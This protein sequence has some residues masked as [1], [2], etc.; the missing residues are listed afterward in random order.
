M[1][2]RRGI[3]IS[4]AA[5][6][7]KTRLA[8]EAVA[9]L[10]GADVVRVAGTE[11]AAGIPFGA[12]AA[13]L[14]AVP[15]PAG[16]RPRGNLFAWAAAALPPAHR[17][18]LFVDDAHLLDRASAAL[19]LHLAL[20][21]QARIVATV[22][23]GARPVDAVTALWKDDLLPRL[24]LA[25]F[26]PAE[27]ARVLAG[28]LDGPIASESADRLFGLTE[29]NV[30]FL[31][32]VVLAGLDSGTLSRRHGLWSWHGSWTLGTRL[33]ELVESRLGL[34]DAAER[35][36][37]EYTAF[38]EPL[39]LDLLIRL[40]GEEAVDRVE[41]RRLIKITRTRRR[42]AVRPAH[43]LYG[44]AVRAA[45]GL[46]ARRRILRRL[47][48]ATEASGARRREDAL[49]MAVWRLDGGA[50]ADPEPLCTAAATAWAALDHESA[51]RLG[52]A[53]VEAGGGVEAAARLAVVLHFM[54]RY[55]EA[56][57]VLD[58]VAGE[59]AGERQRALYV[60]A[61]ALG[62]AW[63][64]GRPA[65]ATDLLTATV[66]GLREPFW[67]Q[68]LRV[69]KAVFLVSG[70]DCAGAL[71]ETAEL[72]ALGPVAPVIDASAGMAESL[73]LAHLG[74]TGRA[75]AIAEAAVAARDSWSDL[76]AGGAP[77]F[78]SACVSALAYAG[79]LRAAE[80]QAEEARR[81]L[82]APG[83]PWRRAMAVWCGQRAMLLR[84]RGRLR[85]ALLA[86]REGQ[87]S[88]GD[89]RTAFAGGLVLGEQAHAAALL[90]EHDVAEAAL[91]QAL[92]RGERN[93]LVGLD[94][95][96]AQARPWLLAA[97]GNLAGAVAEALATAGR[98]RERS[99]WPYA[100][101]ALHDV[102]RLGRPEL[103]ADELA[104]LA[105]RVDGPLAGL[106]ARH[107]AARTGQELEQVAKEFE[108]LE[109]V[110]YAAEAEAGAARA[111]GEAGW[112]RPARA[113]AARAWGLAGNCQGARTPALA[114]LSAPSLTGRER[115]I[116]V[117]VAGG[118]TNRAVAGQFTISV[119]TVTNHL[120]SIYQKLGVNDRESLRRLLG[121]DG[122]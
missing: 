120:A 34:L 93:T 18:V 108:E 109:M 102:V 64:R 57:E 25:P 72:R 39:G 40:A 101:F 122:A 89:P 95:A 73:A 74:E 47:A 96:V 58:R 119:R 3:V 121:P 28:A 100:M 10:T 23:Q 32:E 59:P 43:P 45:T 37:L 65:E 4:G 36:V 13:A 24:E 105:C 82:L 7:G 2:S 46:G 17:L 70:G 42:A 67:Q 104:E 92:E 63:G 111:F 21:R 19:V 116:A 77:S 33:S 31:R 1:R 76:V 99:L 106:L 44:E 60:Y 54:E 14:P 103:V 98:M 87:A 51:I 85:E 35:G 15:P 30:L 53:A 66:A 48:E 11:A 86:T 71:A 113:A 78:K 49:R 69:L 55:D 88:L 22:R 16:E 97:R 112:D 80:R 79:D 6:V 91:A 41:A 110:L 107:A 27:S 29:G 90:G 8:A 75:V 56:D 26:T 115:E 117:A 114:G 94:F 20:Q 68:Y 84:M 118:L 81:M 38:G 50:H 5:G 61:R 52:R 9:E 12:F 62:L 83:A